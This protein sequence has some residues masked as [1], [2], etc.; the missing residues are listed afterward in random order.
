MQEME[1]KFFPI[2]FASKKLNKTEQNY[3][4]TEKEFLAIVW[5]I[6][7]FRSYLHG[8]EFIIETNHDSLQYLDKSKFINA[9]LMRW[10]MMLQQYSC[11]INV[12]KGS[13]NHAADYLSR[14]V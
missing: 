7:K 9:K 10:S 11:R 4:T 12:I 6:K 13:E 3:F 1:G 14:D 2:S 5:A 8:K